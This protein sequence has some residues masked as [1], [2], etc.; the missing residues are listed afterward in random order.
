MPGVLLAAILAVLVRVPFVGRPAFPDESGLLLV[1]RQWHNGGPSLY[2]DLWIDRPPLLVAYWWVADLLGGVG[3]AR[4][5]GCAAI[6]VA[7][8]AAGWA[9]WVIGER[10]GAYWAAG[11]TAALL[12]SPLMAT[13]AINGELLAA[14]FVL[15]SCALTLTAVRR[16]WSVRFEVML[17]VFAGV[18]GSC[19]LLIKQNFAD[20]LIFAVVL[21][22]VSGVRSDLTWRRARRILGWGVTGAAIPLLLT[23]LWAEAAGH[24]FGDLWHALYGFRSDAVHTIA[25]QSFSAPAERLVRLVGVGIISGIVLLSLRYLSTIRRA[26]R[27]DASLAV[28]TA[29]MLTFGYVAVLAGGSFWLHYLIGLVPAVA[30]AAAQL[31]AFSPRHLLSRA[32]I[33]V[34][35]AAAAITPV[36]GVASGAMAD[37]PTETAVTSYLQDARLDDD[38]VIIAYGHANV[39]EAAGLEPG[40]PY[41][42]SLPLRVLDPDLDLMTSTLSGPNAPTWFVGWEPLNSWGID[43]HGRLESALDENYREVA[44]ICDV[45]IYLR[46]GADRDTPPEPTVDCPKP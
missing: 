12:G 5:M 30:L 7:V 29:A 28:A 8:I 21:L 42:W 25:T 19:A 43:E 45:E 36:A 37:D 41:L 23:V 1:A 17:A 24:G 4:L 31:G 20:A 44:K 14:P 39:L 26:I 9:G 46:D 34:V 22:V 15:L 11:S 2:G 6:A 32:A 18:V 27:G 10:R 3:A 40:Y 16:T 13:N 33:G 38:K 35:I